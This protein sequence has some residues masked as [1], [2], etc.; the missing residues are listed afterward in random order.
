M[1]NFLDG[2][3]LLD[4]WS[5]FQRPLCVHDAPNQTPQSIEQIEGPEQADFLK[6]H[7][8]EISNIDPKTW[9]LLKKIRVLAIIT[10]YTFAVY[11]GSAIYLPSVELLASEYRNDIQ[12]AL[13]GLSLYVLGCRFPI[14]S[15]R[16][17]VLTMLIVPSHRRCRPSSLGTP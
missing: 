8:N 12:T 9:P 11:A 14:L 13:L 1:H 2:T 7:N 16:I 6:Y 15:K 10:Y 4:L 3:I 17:G 5:F